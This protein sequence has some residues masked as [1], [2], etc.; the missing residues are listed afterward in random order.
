MATVKWNKPVEGSPTIKA[1]EAVAFIT[2][3]PMRPTVTEGVNGVAVRHA[4]IDQT[5]IEGKAVIVTFYEPGEYHLFC[6]KDPTTMLT[7]VLVQ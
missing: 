1:G 4:C 7:V 3:L 2:T 6:R 5:L